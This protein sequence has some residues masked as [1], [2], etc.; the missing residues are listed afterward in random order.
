[1]SD[2]IDLLIRE[3][4]EIKKAL[5]TVR[6]LGI[7]TAEARKKLLEVEQVFINHLQIEEENIHKVLMKAGQNDLEVKGIIDSTRS[8]STELSIEMIE[9]FHHLELG[10]PGLNEEFTR[11]ENLLNIRMQQ[12]EEILFST[13]K[14]V[15]IKNTNS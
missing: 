1:M 2:L 13:Y 4:L 10:K 7:D 6:A 11:M 9:F 8:E 5:A 14:M 12:E 3:H 15:C